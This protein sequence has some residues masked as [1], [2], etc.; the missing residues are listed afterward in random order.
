MSQ[1]LA[2]RPGTLEVVVRSKVSVGKLSYRV[3]LGRRLRLVV[4]PAPSPRT[5]PAPRESTRKPATADAKEKRVSDQK[6]KRSSVR[7]AVASY[8]GGKGAAT[9]LLS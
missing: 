1:H 9:A 8:L 5:S 3:T 2:T 4:S 6:E 7:Q